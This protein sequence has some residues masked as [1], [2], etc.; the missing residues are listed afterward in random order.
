[1]EYELTRHARKAV[2]ER[3]IPIEWIERVL[4]APARVE[5]DRRDPNV[6]HRLAPIEEFGNRV[7]RVAINATS[8]PLRVVTVHF[9]RTRK[10]AL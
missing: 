10:G 6:E 8:V 7:L 2:E 9:D 4:D 1:M 3:E 5:A